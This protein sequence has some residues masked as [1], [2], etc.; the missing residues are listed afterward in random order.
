M[1]T[2]VMVCVQLAD[3][4]RPLDIQHGLY[5][6]HL[7]RRRIKPSPA[8]HIPTAVGGAGAG[9]ARP[10]FLTEHARGRALATLWA[11]G[12][13]AAAAAELAAL[14]QQLVGLRLL[15]IQVEAATAA[16][17]AATRA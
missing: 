17:Q 12:A 11:A 8:R 3:G 5:K 2:Q 14:A 13:G 6:V 1:T 16:E 15:G 4:E 10:L 7:H 9:R